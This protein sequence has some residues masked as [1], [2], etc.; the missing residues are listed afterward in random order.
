[1]MVKAIDLPE[2][3]IEQEIEREHRRDA[4]RVGVR[5]VVFRHVLEVH[6]VDPGNQR[7]DR[8]NRRPTASFL[9]T[10]VSFKLIMPD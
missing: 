3:K 2:P 7:R 6:A 8:D 4:N 9:V 1:M 5:E 10:S